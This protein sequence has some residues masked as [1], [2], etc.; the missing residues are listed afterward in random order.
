MWCRWMIR[1]DM[2]AVASIE[3]DT[4]GDW[5]EDDFLRRLR[6]RNCIGYVVEMVS[7]VVGGC[8]VGFAVYELGDG[9]MEVLNMACVVPVARRVLLDRLEEKAESYRR[10]LSW[11][12]FATVEG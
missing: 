8:V 1:K 12:A 9:V 5:C 2:P 3:R 4:G 7:P 10:V 6:L 11:S